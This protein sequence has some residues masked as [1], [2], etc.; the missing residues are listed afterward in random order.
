M[1]EI[2]FRVKVGL[3]EDCHAKAQRLDHAGD[4][5][6]PETWMINIAV[7]CDTNII[8]LIP[9]LFFHLFITDG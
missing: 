7:P 6:D 4:N 8:G 2:Y 5:R 3:G 9:T 1:G